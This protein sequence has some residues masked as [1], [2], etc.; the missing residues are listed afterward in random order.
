[1]RS[2]DEETD[3]HGDNARMRAPRGR[4]TLFGAAVA[5][6]IAAV[7]VGVI[8]VVT[9]SSHSQTT[10]ADYL[11][12]VAAVCRV[13][14]PRLD[15]IRPPD[16]AEPA[17]VIDAVDRVLPLI[18][19]Q[20]H[21]VKALEPPDE[22]RPRVERW[23]ALQERRLGKL[24]KAQAAGGRQDFRALSVAYVD[25]ALAGTETGRLAREL[26]VPHPPC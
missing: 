13:Y 11:A 8:L 15:R 4:R 20:L 17:N 2:A 18:S 10:R 5:A 22:L 24:E 19:A 14:G 26:G 7:A 25:F 3:R 23:I 21:D 16:V 9:P 6:L 1:V 12:A